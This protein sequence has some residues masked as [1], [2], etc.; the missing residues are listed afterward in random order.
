MKPFKARSA[1]R[2][3]A[4]MGLAAYVGDGCYWTGL[5]GGLGK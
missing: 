4:V 2:L 1:G 5:R 3:G